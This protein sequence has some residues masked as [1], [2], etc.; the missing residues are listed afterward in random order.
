MNPSD[1]DR[2]TD[3]IMRRGL[4]GMAE[5]DL[6]RAFCEQCNAAGLPT[7]RVL[8]FIDTLHPVHEGRIFRWRDDGEEE[9]PV[10]EYGPSNQGEAAESWQRSP[11]FHLLQSGNEELRR[12]LGFGEDAG[13]SIIQEMKDAG[14]T[15]YVVFVHRFSREGSLGEMDSV[16]SAWSTKHPDGFSD[17]NM[18]ALRRLVPA[19]ALAIKSAA[20]AQIAGT[21][22]DVYLGHDAGQRVLS[23]RIQRGVADRIEA[24][25]W[26]SDLR[27][28]TTIT[29]TA[30]PNE[31]IP[32]LNDYADAV[33]TAIHEAGGDVLKLIGDGTLAIFRADDPA[34]ACASALAAEADMRRRVQ[35]LNERRKAGEHPTTSV[36]VGLHIGE[37]F[38]GNIGSVDRLDFT[39]VGPAVNETSRIASMCRS[40]DRPL[41][42]SSDFA[43]TLPE[44]PRATLVSVG[45]F[46]LRGVG[47]AKELFTLDPAVL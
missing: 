40:V 44:A 24:V 39:V 11:F 46:A 28:F 14:H 29:D 10:R 5:P 23:G 26:F 7:N 3:W 4:E 27:S 45:R 35:E 8:L 34:A 33:I 30:R 25:L 37:V 32:L 43:T 21:L 47:R 2:L 12:R 36:Y 16:S 6:L 38:Y 18:A 42:I 1:V 20:L 22:V 31:I 9:T 13:F 41:L 19:L 17:A 15:D